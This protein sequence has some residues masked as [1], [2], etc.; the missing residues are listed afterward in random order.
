MRLVPRSAARCF[1]SPATPAI[2]AG[3][4]DVPPGYRREKRDAPHLAKSYEVYHAPDGAVLKSKP[5][6]WVHYNA[7]RKRV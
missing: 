2:P 3:H 6:T 4:D 7:I 1:C 5:Q